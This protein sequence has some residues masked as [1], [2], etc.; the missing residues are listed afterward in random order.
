[1]G[2]G[3]VPRVG[4][5]NHKKREPWL[6]HGGTLFFKQQVKEPIKEPAKDKK[7]KLPER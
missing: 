2:M 7:Q 6:K 4:V 5:E 3:R 1:M